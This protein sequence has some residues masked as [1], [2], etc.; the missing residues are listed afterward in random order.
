MRVS[1]PARDLDDALHHIAYEYVAL[2]SAFQV[3]FCPPTSAVFAAAFDSFLLH[4]RNLVEFFQHEQDRSRLH[5]D[6]LR[7][8]DYV[9]GWRTPNLPQWNAW[10]KHI[11]IL[12]AHVS[13]K[14]NR[15]HDEIER[16]RQVTVSLKGTTE[17]IGP[18]WPGSTAA[19]MTA[20]RSR[21]PN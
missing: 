4:Y 3:C 14:R 7:A 6:D 20:C 18:S 10:R 1:R 17:R 8:Q 21:G 9:Q 5:V 16:L 12:L 13:T 19:R 11:H 2:R 15:I